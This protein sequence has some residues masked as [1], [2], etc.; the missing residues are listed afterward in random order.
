MQN[1]IPTY[2]Q[3]SPEM[4]KAFRKSLTEAAVAKL[5]RGARRG[6]FD[7][8]IAADDAASGRLRLIEWAR[9]AAEKAFERDA[10][11]FGAFPVHPD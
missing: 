10:A 2:L 7:A 6:S 11:N 9:R 1:N 8:L 5:D 3:E 4:L